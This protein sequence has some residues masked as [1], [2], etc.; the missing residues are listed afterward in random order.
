MLWGKY[1]DFLLSSPFWF[2]INSYGTHSHTQ[3]CWWFPRIK[4]R[5]NVCSQPRCLFEKPYIGCHLNTS[6]ALKFKKRHPLDT[7]APLHEMAP[8]LGRHFHQCR[9]HVRTHLYT[10]QRESGS[11]GNPTNTCCMSDRSRHPCK[12]TGRWSGCR[13]CPGTRWGGSH[14][15][16]GAGDKLKCY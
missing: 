16:L 3:L 10:V 9:R 7:C 8:L 1:V 13:C 5:Q 15:L 4:T 14:K 11:A 2:L 12:D 6:D